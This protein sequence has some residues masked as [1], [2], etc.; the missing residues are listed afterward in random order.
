MNILHTEASPGW[1]G[2]ELRIL[3]EAEGMR[4]RGH[5]VILA[6]QE[7][8]GL[9]R[10]ARESGLL[11][12]ELPFRKR[13]ALFLFSELMRIVRKHG[14]G[15]LNTHSSL[16]AWIGGIVGRIS[17]AKVIRTRHLSTPISR[18]L[19]SLILYKW[20]ADNV[21][22]TCQETA[23]KICEQLK[24]SHKRCFSVPTG[25]DPQ[26]LHIDPKEVEKFRV[27][28]GIAPTDILAGTLCVLRGWKGVS[29]LLYAAA[30][31]REIPHLKWVIVGSGPSE[32]HFKEECR[33]LKLEGS[34]F[35]TGHLA[36]PYT[37]LAAM[38]IF[39]LLSWANEGVSQASLQAA[40]LA[41]PL[42]TTPVGGLREV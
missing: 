23:T 13:R 27:S 35:F 33:K 16:D 32:A 3:R 10:P 41:K 24:L 11:V 2:Q 40:L 4:A 42:I 6:I 19:K 9:V 25:V 15:I 37:A 17:G 22:T 36:P 1:G 7:G 21:V 30:L 29:Y 14:I 5:Q 20:L 38:D 12:Y 28:L 34:V 31:L 8:G 39:L 18:G 26:T